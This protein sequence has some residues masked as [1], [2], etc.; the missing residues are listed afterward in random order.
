MGKKNDLKKNEKKTG[1]NML[2]L[3]PYKN[4][5]AKT[6]VTWCKDEISFRKWSCWSSYHEI[7]R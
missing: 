5:D 6:I 2:R 4:C 1:G 3:R 7:Y